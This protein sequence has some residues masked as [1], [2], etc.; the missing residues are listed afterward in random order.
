MKYENL[1]LQNVTI[2]TIFIQGINPLEMDI[3]MKY[4][5]YQTIFRY[6]KAYIRFGCLCSNGTVQV[7]YKLRYINV[8]Q[9]DSIYNKAGL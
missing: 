2:A 9:T 1:K 5:Y 4:Q 3:H 7:D 8:G 6:I